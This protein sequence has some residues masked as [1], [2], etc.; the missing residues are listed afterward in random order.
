MLRQVIPG[1]C[2]TGAAALRRQAGFMRRALVATLARPSP[3]WRTTLPPAL[4]PLATMPVVTLPPALRPLATMPVVAL[5][6]VCR[7]PMRALR[8]V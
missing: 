8:K 5:P 2:S 3:P 7:L 6:R 1:R 4:R